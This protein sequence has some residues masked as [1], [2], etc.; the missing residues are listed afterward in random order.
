V[1]ERLR[2]SCSWTPRRCNVTVSSRPSRSDAGARMGVRQLARQLA[3]TFE[4]DG[5][6]GELPGGSQAPLDGGPVA[7]GEVIEDVALLVDGCS[8]GPGPGRGPR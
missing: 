8:A 5:V 6:I 7:L 1:D 4:R 2:Q 3:Q